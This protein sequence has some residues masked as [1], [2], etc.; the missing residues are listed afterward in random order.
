MLMKDD[1]L[2]YDDLDYYDW[3]EDSDRST[4]YEDNANLMGWYSEDLASEY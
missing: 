4:E 3:Y 2:D 1:D